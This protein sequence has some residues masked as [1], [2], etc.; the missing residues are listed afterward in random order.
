MCDEDCE[1]QFVL[2]N[3]NMFEF[4]LISWAVFVVCSLVGIYTYRFR[5]ACTK[6]RN[7]GHKPAKDYGAVDKVEV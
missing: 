6:N 2:D 1:A 7:N 3:W 4:F 5:E